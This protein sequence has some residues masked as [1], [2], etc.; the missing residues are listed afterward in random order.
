M[1]VHA[2]YQQKGVATFLLAE[3]EKYA[4][5]HRIEMI[6]SEVSLT[7]QTFFERKGYGHRTRTKKMGQPINILSI[8]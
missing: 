4:T 3:I 6:T 2:D 5:C 8:S 1:F 7:A